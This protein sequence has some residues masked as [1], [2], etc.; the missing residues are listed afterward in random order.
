MILKPRYCKEYK[1]VRKGWIIKTAYQTLAP[2]EFETFCEPPESAKNVL[3]FENYDGYIDDPSAA[4]CELVPVKVS[5]QIP[6]PDNVPDYN[7]VDE[8]EYD[9]IIV[10]PKIEYT[11]TYYKFTA[12]DWKTT[13]SQTLCGIND[14]PMRLTHHQDNDVSRFV[15]ETEKYYAVVE[16]NGQLI[17]VPLWRYQY[18]HIQPGDTIKV[19]NIRGLL[20]IVYIGNQMNPSLLERI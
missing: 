1:V 14:D 3:K 8:I 15:L 5:S 11:G 2:K 19:G 18:E 6:D 7:D 20:P 13:R 4:Y 16:D 10:V 9:R 17:R 12:N